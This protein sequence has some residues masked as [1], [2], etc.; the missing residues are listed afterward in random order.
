MLI[1]HCIM[2]QG[3]KFPY[4]Y[5]KAIILEIKVILIHLLLNTDFLMV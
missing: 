2:Y 5:S 3:K 1:I 4:K